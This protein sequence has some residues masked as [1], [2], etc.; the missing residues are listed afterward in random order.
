MLVEPGGKLQLQKV[1]VGR[2]FGDTI[3]I[4]SGLKGGET[5]VK[6]PDVS[7]QNG[8]VVIP[9]ESGTIAND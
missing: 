6:Q 4:Q 2:D 3:D 8:E 1:L 9:V 5:V 7:L